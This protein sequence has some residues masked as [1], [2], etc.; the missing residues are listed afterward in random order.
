[1]W[2]DQRPRGDSID[3][4]E[5][6]LGI[7][8]GEGEAGTKRSPARRTAVGT[9]CSRIAS[10]RPAEPV[11]F[12]EGLGASIV[13]GASAGEVAEAGANDDGGTPKV[14]LRTLDLVY[15]GDGCEPDESPLGKSSS[16]MTCE[17]LLRCNEARATR[18]EPKGTEEGAR[19]EL[20][21]DD[22][23]P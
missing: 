13:D 19:L 22:A 11:L 12:P 10:A 14:W 8:R 1:M 7:V 3:A 6:L 23:A 21:S 2:L 16:S 20:E 18:E 5:A 15:P 17:F 4:V 9:R